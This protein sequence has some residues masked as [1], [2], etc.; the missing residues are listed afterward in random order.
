MAEKTTEQKAQEVADFLQGTCAMLHGALAEF[1]CEELED[2][3]KFCSC[4]DNLVFCC[5]DCGWWC[6]A[7]DYGEEDGKCEDC[8]PRAE[9]D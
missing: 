1:D 4:L 9:D 6:E 5:D 8:S 7:G 2:D 3:D